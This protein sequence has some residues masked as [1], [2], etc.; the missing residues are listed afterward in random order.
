MK[1]YK[2]IK[3]KS[4]FTKDIDFEEQLNQ[5]TRDGWTVISIANNQHGGIVKAVLERDKNR[6][7]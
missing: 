5:Y 7:Y 2:I 1:E 3:K 4:M 6:S